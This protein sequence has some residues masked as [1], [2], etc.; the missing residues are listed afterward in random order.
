[1]AIDEESS[2][3]TTFLLPTG[4]YRYLRGPMGLAP[5]LDEWNRKSDEMIAA[6][7]FLIGSLKYL[8]I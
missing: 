2:L 3:K 5:T 7:W 8:D 4:R 6:Q 1:M